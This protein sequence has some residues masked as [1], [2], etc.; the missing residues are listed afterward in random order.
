[1]IPPNSPIWPKMKQP[2]LLPVSRE[3]TENES[4]EPKYWLCFK[5]KDIRRAC[6][7]AGC[8]P[9][10]IEGCIKNMKDADGSEDCTSCLIALVSDLNIE[11][12]CKT[13]KELTDVR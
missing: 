2:K 5:E 10:M 7:K 8:N 11:P 3:M 6:D 13:L 12:E 4:I 1:M 9:E